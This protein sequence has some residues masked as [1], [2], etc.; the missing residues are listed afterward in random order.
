[1]VFLAFFRASNRLVIGETDVARLALVCYCRMACLGFTFS[2][3]NFCRAW[4]ASCNQRRFWVAIA[5]CLHLMAMPHSAESS[6]SYR[7]LLIH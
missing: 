4:D 6:E 2:K 1:M 5:A 3:E 7:S